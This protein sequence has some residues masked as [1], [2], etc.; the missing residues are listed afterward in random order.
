MSLPPTLDPQSDALQ[1][2][3]RWFELIAEGKWTEALSLIDLPS[4]YGQAWTRAEIEAQLAEYG[5]AGARLTSPAT[6]TGHSHT[7]TGRFDDRSGFY[8]DCDFPLNGTWSDLSAQFEFL[9]VNGRYSV[10]LQDIHVL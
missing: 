2:V 8:L 5:P 1:F 6:A 3:L 7:N 9:E 4:S 10:R